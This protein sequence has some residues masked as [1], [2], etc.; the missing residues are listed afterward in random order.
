MFEPKA[1]DR[2]Q[3]LRE[4][5]L[6]GRL[7]PAQLRCT[8][9]IGH[10][11]ISFPRL[12]R[13]SSVRALHGILHCKLVMF[14]LSFSSRLYQLIAH[15]NDFKGFGHLVLVH[16]LILRKLINLKIVDFTP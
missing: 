4:K 15:S 9:Q 5:E 12:T 14:F 2:E 6:V 13:A 1:R 3:K 16:T 11:L 10:E 7:T 8:N